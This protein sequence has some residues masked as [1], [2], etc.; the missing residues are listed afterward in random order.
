MLQIWVALDHL[1]Q[2]ND[3]KSLEAL[4]DRTCG[5]PQLC[6]EILPEAPQSACA[7]DITSH[8]YNLQ[9]YVTSHLMLHYSIQS[10]GNTITVAQPQDC[11]A[12]SG[13]R[14]RSWDLIGPLTL[15]HKQAGGGARILRVPEFAELDKYSVKYLRVMR[16]EEQRNLPLQQ[17]VHGRVRYGEAIVR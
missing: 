10:A 6:R 8:T 12:N 2:T 3:L 5:G 11:T 16:D 15:D 17:V 13:A 4:V 7:S 14:V 9:A 1:D